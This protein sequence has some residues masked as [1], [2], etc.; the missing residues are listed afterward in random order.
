M[1]AFEYSRARV[2]LNL[3]SRSFKSQWYDCC[4]AGLLPCC[5]AYVLPWC[6]IAD[7]NKA[8]GTQDD[9]IFDTLCL[10]GSV[11]RN[12]YRKVKQVSGHCVG[13]CCLNCCPCCLLVQMMHDIGPE[14]QMLNIT[15]DEVKRSFWV[16]APTSTEM[17]R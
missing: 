5:Y 13:D 6:A 3:M 16:G 14:F 2:C 17:I 15:G 9:Y 4:A 7:I 1:G 10:N 12:R 8:I 11:L